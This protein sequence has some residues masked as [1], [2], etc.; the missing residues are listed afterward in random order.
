MINIKKVPRKVFFRLNPGI[1]RTDS[2]TK[3]N[4]LGGPD[5]KFGIS[6]ENIIP[7]IK[8]ALSY[9]SKDIGLH[10]M[11]GSC[12]MNLSYWKSTIEI[13]M[14]TIL[15][16]KLETGIIISDINIGGGIGIPYRKGEEPVNIELLVNII[17]DEIKRYSDEIYGDGGM[18]NLCMENG[19]FI[20][21]PYGW[22]VSRCEVIKESYGKKYCG[23]DACMSHLM[24]PGMY[25]SY[26]YISHISSSCFDKVKEAKDIEIKEE[27]EK[28]ESVNIVG[29]LCE[30]NDWFAKDRLMPKSKVGDLFIIHDTGAHSHSM[31]FQYN[32]KLRAPEFIIFKEEE[33]YY[34]YD[35][36]LNKSS[37]KLLE[38]SKKLL[39]IRERETIFHYLST[40]V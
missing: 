20:T 40:V 25:G 23:L 13:M 32:G 12:V 21:G 27:E 36:S 2:S 5:A 18:P 26:H 10:M 16:V 31:G 9:G 35:K 17:Y 15:K 1:G 33:T 11:T 8:K 7:A 38:S 4:V 34:N 6:T 3:S 30:N 37:T 24:R 19:R 22:L 39:Q 28:M 29:S 14:K